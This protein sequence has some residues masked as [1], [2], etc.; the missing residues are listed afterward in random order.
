MRLFKEIRDLLS[1]LPPQLE[2][3]SQNAKLDLTYNDYLAIKEK[4]VACLI[5]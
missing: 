5:G 4:G 1:P 2:Y 3:K